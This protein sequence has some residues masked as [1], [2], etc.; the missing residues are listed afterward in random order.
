MS[1]RQIEGRKNMGAG[2][3]RASAKMVGR[4]RNIRG[5]WAFPELKRAEM[6]NQK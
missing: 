2:S 3:R 5:A 6:C 1:D 4:D